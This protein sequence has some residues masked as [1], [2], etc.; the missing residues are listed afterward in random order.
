[1]ERIKEEMEER[2][3]LTVIFTSTTSDLVQMD[4]IKNTCNIRYFYS[5][6][7]P[8]K[9]HT[10]DSSLFIII[11][12]QLYPKS[13]GRTEI[14]NKLSSFLSCIGSIKNLWIETCVIFFLIF[15]SELMYIITYLM[16]VCLPSQSA[17]ETHKQ[18]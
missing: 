17:L 14:Q 10:K 2:H 3:I 8:E 1:M 4:S 11:T 12:N 18:E 9:A 7:L 13:S 15:N 5:Y 6:L 16:G